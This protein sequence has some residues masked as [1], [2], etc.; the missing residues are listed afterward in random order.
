M[1]DA[2]KTYLIRSA[3]S[4]PDR[5]AVPLLEADRILWLP[6][7][8]VRAFGQF[9]YDPAYLYVRLRA[10]EKNIRAAYTAPLSPVHQDSCL[11]FFF[12]QE[13]DNCYFNFEINP[14]GCLHI[15]YGSGRQ[16]RSVV[17]PTG[18]DPFGIRTGKNPSFPRPV[19]IPSVSGREKTRTAGRRHIGSRFPSCAS[20]GRTSPLRERS[21]PT[22]TNAG[23]SRIRNTTFPGI[24]SPPPRRIFTG[25]GTLES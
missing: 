23:T 18:P 2:V 6:D 21:G 15:G 3:C 11:E 25:P 16:N 22:C 8:G 20:S 14:N 5:D 17:S 24:P 19:R 7:C 10:V 12:M 1:N 9:C 4:G 13:G